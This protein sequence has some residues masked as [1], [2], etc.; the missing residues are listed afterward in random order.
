MPLLLSTAQVAD[1][2]SSSNHLP[3]LLLTA[4]TPALL[5]LLPAAQV[6]D[7]TSIGLVVGGGAAIA[8]LGYTLVMTDPQKRW[9]GDREAAVQEAREAAVQEGREAAVQHR[10]WRR[11][12]RR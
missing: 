4:C 8:A 7:G 10:W 1:G 3:A 5:P 11:W 6:A 2:T 9:V 12:R